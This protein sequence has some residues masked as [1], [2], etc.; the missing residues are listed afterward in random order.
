MSSIG[1]FHDILTDPLKASLEGFNRMYEASMGGESY[2]MESAAHHIKENAGKQIRP[3]LLILVA[4]TYGVFGDEV[5]NGAVFIELLHTAT[6]LHDDVV[7]NSMMRRGNPSVNALYGNRK[8]VLI[9]DFLLSGAMYRVIQTGN[10]G[11]ITRLSKLGLE[12]SEGELMQ[13]DRV[14]LGTTS[15]EEYFK[16][17]HHK[18]A[19]LIRVSMEVGAILAGEEDEEV[20]T[21]IG[22]AG[23]KM[24]LAFQIRDDIFDYLPTREMGKPSGI[25]LRE[26][27]ITLPLIHALERGGRESEKVLKVLRH[28]TLA[29]DQVEYI[30]DFT[31]RK[32][33]V[34]YAEE[35][36]WRLLDEA[37]GLLMNTLSPSEC[38]DV[39]IRVCDYIGERNK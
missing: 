3:L 5:L 7:D 27:K 30:L 19:S 12:L 32:G 33:G 22:E 38:R 10:T 29:D 20:V 17:I 9:G 35:V 13:M 16:I 31:R 2:T 39:L 28:T 1:D 23:V 34:E 24:G 18:T 6:L 14:E 37:K 25:D 36:M 11:I 15:E 8:A 26:H 4:G 21:T